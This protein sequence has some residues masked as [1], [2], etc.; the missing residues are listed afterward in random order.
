M[1]HIVTA[2]KEEASPVMRMASEDIDITVM[3]IGK[4]NAAF[5]VGRL[6]PSP[7]TRNNLS[8]DVV[9]NIG[10][11]C[12]KDLKG[13]FVVNKITD[14]ASGKDYYPD[15]LRIKGLPEA[16]LV[17]SDRTV[18]S[19]EPG[20]LYEMEASAVWQAASKL[21][22]PDRIIFLKIV[23]DSGDVDK[24]TRSYIKDL[25]DSY[26]EQLTETVEY[27]RSTIELR[28]NADDV[29]DICELLSASSSMRIQ[30]SELIRFSQ[31][32]GIDGREL[33]MNEANGKCTRVLGKEVISRVRAKLTS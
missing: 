11:C 25:M 12:S 24:L 20:L 15:V 10:C 33:F 27:I 16:A 28:K 13:M 26:S 21:L 9:I 8:S 19:P 23:S 30:I 18:N 17:T 6:F 7:L 22:S 32:M 29:D 2:I 5:T 1:I 14:E 4:V 3:G 31:S